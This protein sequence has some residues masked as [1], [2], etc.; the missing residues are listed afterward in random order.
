MVAGSKD[1]L[2]FLHSLALFSVCHASEI[3]TC[4]LVRRS[5]IGLQGLVRLYVIAV[6]R[7]KELLRV[8]S[9]IERTRSR[10]LTGVPQWR[11]LFLSI[12]FILSKDFSCLTRISRYLQ[13]FCIYIPDIMRKQLDPRIPALIANGVKANHR[14]FF[15]MVGDKG[16]DQV[17]S[18][19]LQLL[20]W[21]ANES[22]WSTC[23]FCYPK[24]GSRRDQTSCGATRKSW[25]L[26]REFCTRNKA[27][28][29]H[30][31]KREAKIKRDVKRGIREANEQDPF[32]L[33][34]AVTDI[35]YTYYKDSAKV[36][37]QTFGMLVLQ[38]YEAI[39]PNLLA[40]TIETVE[41]GGI[42]VLLLRTMSSLKQLYT[43]SMVSTA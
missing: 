41:G 3:S 20:F 25:A 18:G 9:T 2:S 5:T 4:R 32:E 22:R 19:G 43:M 10:Q 27:D 21:V 39:T 28:S 23:T 33:F 29:R 1:S 16:R 6:E 40:R 8:T 17:S 36:L 37:G 38:D 15:V 30:R 14:S 7:E 13:P 12:L 34:V 11:H 26:R 24:Q 35:R 42:V 31:K